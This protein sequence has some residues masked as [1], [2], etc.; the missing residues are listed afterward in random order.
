VQVAVGIRKTAI[1]VFSILVAAMIGQVVMMELVH[2]LTLSAR[3]L[4]QMV[5]QASR[6]TAQEHWLKRRIS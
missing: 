4:L 2:C 1:P 3:V 6:S 5:L